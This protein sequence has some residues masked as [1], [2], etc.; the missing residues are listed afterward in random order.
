LTGFERSNVVRDD[1]AKPHDFDCMR[2]QALITMVPQ[3]HEEKEPRQECDDDNADGGARQELEMKM[4]WA[5]EPGEG[6]SL[7]NSSAHLRGWIGHGGLRHQKFPKAGILP[8]LW[9][10]MIV[11]RP[12]WDGKISTGREPGIVRQGGLLFDRAK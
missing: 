7:E 5:K 6:P 8:Y 2:A 1:A 3:G 10:A 12:K 9:S 11:R 4:L